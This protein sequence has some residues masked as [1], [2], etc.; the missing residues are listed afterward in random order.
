MTLCGSKQIWKGVI[1]LAGEACKAQCELRNSPS[2]DFFWGLLFPSQHQTSLLS[3]LI[4]F[5][6]CLCEQTGGLQLHLLMEIALTFIFICWPDCYPVPEV[7]C[8]YTF[9]LKLACLV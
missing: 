1:K 6:G 7:E 5:S 3:L 2:T 9:L 4:L 8:G